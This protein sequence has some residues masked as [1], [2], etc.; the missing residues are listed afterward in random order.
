MDSCF[1]FTVFKSGI[2]LHVLA[3]TKSGKSIQVEIISYS[4]F[5]A[6]SVV[7]N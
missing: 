2:V 7:K 1:W 6:L 4:V 5:S 3:V